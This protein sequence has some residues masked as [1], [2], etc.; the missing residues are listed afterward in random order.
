MTVNVEDARENY[1]SAR[2]A[3]HIREV[4]RD[5]LVVTTGVALVL[6]SMWVPVHG[7][8]QITGTMLILGM[9]AYSV[10]LWAMTTESRSSHWGLVILGVALLLAPLAM[11]FPSGTAVAA[12]VAVVAGAIIAA[13]GVLGLMNQRPQRA[14]AQHRR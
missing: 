9:I 11:V 13:V 14:V 6:L 5:I 10:G 8:L 1:A 2:D 4:R 3:E 7:D 12:A